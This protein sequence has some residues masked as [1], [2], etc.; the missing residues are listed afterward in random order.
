[1]LSP[2]LKGR[3]EYRTHSFIAQIFEGEEQMASVPRMNCA[4]PK[5]TPLLE[6]P[7]GFME[8][9][10][11]LH[12]AFTPLQQALVAKRA[13]VLRSAHEG[14]LPEHLPASE[15]TIS[16]WK[17]ALPDWCRDQRNQMTGPADDA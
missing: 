11:P 1:M 10:Q 16:D 7:A 12:H 6:L 4:P 5:F 3:S 8:F 14:R 17:I 13:E 15:V 9:L 2:H